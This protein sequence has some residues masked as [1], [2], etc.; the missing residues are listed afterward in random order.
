MGDLMASG[1]SGPGSS[2]A[3]LGPSVIGQVTLLSQT[4]HRRFILIRHERH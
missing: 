4:F 1:L 3:D 2:P